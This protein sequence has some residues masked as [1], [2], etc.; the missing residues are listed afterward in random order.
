MLRKPAIFT[1][2][3][4]TLQ[5]RPQVPVSVSYLSTNMIYLS[6]IQKPT[7]ELEVH[8]SLPASSLNVS[9]TYIKYCIYKVL[10][11]IVFSVVIGVSC[12]GADCG[13]QAESNPPGL[14]TQA[15]T[16]GQAVAG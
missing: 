1:L 6:T 5:N 3:I 7:P 2:Y 10:I 14:T 11:I 15:D 4:S 8:L 13:D 16:C 9:T 12:R